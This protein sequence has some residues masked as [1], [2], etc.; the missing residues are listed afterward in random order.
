[1]NIS[2]DSVFLFVQGGSKEDKHEKKGEYSK[3]HNSSEQKG[4][5]G[6][7]GKEEEHSHQSS[8]A[9]KTGHKSKQ[10][11]QKHKQ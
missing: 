11:N 8:Y 6:H 5:K 3:G 2:I 4:H 9:K 1:M 10:H 7:Q